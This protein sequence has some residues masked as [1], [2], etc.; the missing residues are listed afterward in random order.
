[1]II[2]EISIISSKIKNFIFSYC[3]KY[4]SNIILRTHLVNKIVIQNLLLACSKNL[5]AFARER[6]VIQQLFL[7]KGGIVKSEFL[8]MA[9]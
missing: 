2:A 3:S 4:T 7:R 8:S 1:M 5:S 6:D 9:P